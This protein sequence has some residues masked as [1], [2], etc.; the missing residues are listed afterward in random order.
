MTARYVPIDEFVSLVEWLISQR[1]GSTTWRFC[2][3]RIGFE[4]PELIGNSFGAQDGLRRLNQFG[5]TLAAAARRSD[6]VA[7]K[8]SV[9]WVLSPECEPD[10]LG[11]R[12]QGMIDSVGE[13]GLDIVSCYVS[14]H[15][16]PH[17]EV[18]E[19]ADGWQLLDSFDRLSQGHR[20][21]AAPS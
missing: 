21:A 15:V 16:F 17:P 4:H 9:F 3:F 19:V 7:R 8:L 12:L 13:F 14:A 1:S 5:L 20:A 11:K 2:V 6:V 18:G 10:T